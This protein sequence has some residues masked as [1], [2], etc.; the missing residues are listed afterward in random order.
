MPPKKKTNARSTKSK[1][2]VALQS[3]SK[4]S[5]P[6]EKHNKAA[7]ITI[8]LDNDQ[9]SNEKKR[10]LLEDESKDHIKLKIPKKEDLTID[11]KVMKSF[12]ANIPN[13][14]FQNTSKFCKESLLREIRDMERKRS[15][16][17][18]ELKKSIAALMA[19]FE[20]LDS[21]LKDLATTVAH[22][23]F[24]TGTLPFSTSL[25]RLI[26]QQLAVDKVLAD[27]A[28]GLE[29]ADVAEAWFKLIST[30]VNFI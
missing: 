20:K 11:V 15:L 12:I 17:E 13:L 28:F 5:E 10:M 6:T 26:R 21:R 1:D 8:N 30:R 16:A 3:F 18:S 14:C 23:A 19:Q 22:P 25:W 27:N 4:S 2:A 9:K 7:K 24:R 29:S